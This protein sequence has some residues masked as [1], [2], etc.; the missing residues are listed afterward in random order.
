MDSEAFS[1]PACELAS[2]LDSEVAES[3][4]GDASEL[5]CEDASLLLSPGMGGSAPRYFV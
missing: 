1:V 4:H 3:G 2:E 5:D